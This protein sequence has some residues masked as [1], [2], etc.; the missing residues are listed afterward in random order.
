MYTNTILLLTTIKPLLLLLLYLV[1]PRHSVSIVEATH[2]GRHFVF[3]PGNTVPE[4]AGWNPQTIHIIRRSDSASEEHHLIANLNET[5][6]A[7]RCND[8]FAIASTAAGHLRVVSLSTGSEVLKS[9][10]VWT[11]GGAAFDCCFDISETLVC[12]P[13]SGQ[14]VGRLKVVTFNNDMAAP[15]VTWVSECDI[16]DSRLC[17]VALSENGKLAAC[18]SKSGKY[19]YVVSVGEGKVIRTFSRGSTAAEVLALRFSPGG[20]FLALNSVHGTYHLFGVSPEIS[21]YVGW[22]GYVWSNERSKLSGQRDI[23]KCTIAVDRNGN[24]SSFKLVAI[25]SKSNFVSADVSVSDRELVFSPP[26]V[27]SL[28]FN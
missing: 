8:T 22:M 10:T 15:A 14:K 6:T 4:T 3:V 13:A 17:C 25:D 1:T 2:T 12:F 27:T 28:V 16:R 21:N 7:L 20:E 11:D 23:K 19:A 5:I 26:N 24:G 18:A 9:D